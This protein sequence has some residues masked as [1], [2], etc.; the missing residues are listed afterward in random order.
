MA[1]VIELNESTRIPLVWVFVAVPTLVGTIAWMTTAYVELAQ[2]RVSI[3]KQ[4]S[5][6]EA[7]DRNYQTIRDDLILIKLK[8]GIEK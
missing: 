2:A 5:R 8:L 1:K 4:E 7:V 3:D 6:L